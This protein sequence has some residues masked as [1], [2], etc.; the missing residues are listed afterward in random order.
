MLAHLVG[1]HWLVALLVQRTVEAVHAL[2]DLHP[3]G[4][5]GI[6]VGATNAAAAAAA[7]ELLRDRCK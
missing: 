3:D 1:I 7:A 5:G 2:R 6:T 4:R